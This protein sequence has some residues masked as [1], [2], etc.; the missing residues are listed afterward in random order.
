MP[1][2]VTD[3]KTE[4][5][6]TRASIKQTKQRITLLEAELSEA[7]KLEAEAARTAKKDEKSA[8]EKFNEARNRRPDP[9]ATQTTKR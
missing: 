2:P 4:L 1:R 9:F 7:K 6:A 5:D 3:I 8:A